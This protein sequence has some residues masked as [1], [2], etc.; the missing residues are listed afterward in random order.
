[1]RSIFSSYGLASSVLHDGAFNVNEVNQFFAQFDYYSYTTQV[2]HAPAHSSR[3]MQKL[4]HCDDPSSLI[5][6]TVD[7]VY[8]QLKKLNANKASGPDGISPRVLKMCADQLCRVLHHIFSLSLS[9]SKIPV[10]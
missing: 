7:E 8:A 2:V 6:I 10:M 1:M 9:Q 5:T 4:E 3:S